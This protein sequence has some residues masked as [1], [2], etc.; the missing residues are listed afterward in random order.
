MTAIDLDKQTIIYAMNQ[1]KLE[2][3]ELQRDLNLS[4]QSATRLAKKLH[5]GCVIALQN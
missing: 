2:A 5:P 4:I 1:I 3:E